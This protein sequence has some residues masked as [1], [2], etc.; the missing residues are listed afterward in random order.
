MIKSL[1]PN[2][3]NEPDSSTYKDKDIKGKLEANKVIISTFTSW[4]ILI[5][6]KVLFTSSSFFQI[7]FFSDPP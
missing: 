7:V 3:V 2:N 1:I 5:P 4:S 6:I